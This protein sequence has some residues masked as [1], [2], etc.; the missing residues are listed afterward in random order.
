MPNKSAMFVILL[1]V[2]SDSSIA[3][4]KNVQV[5]MGGIDEL[6]ILPINGCTALFIKL[7]RPQTGVYSQF[8]A[9]KSAVDMI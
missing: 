1:K 8:T 4:K 3:Q 9:L 7:S 5:A 2:A 6:I